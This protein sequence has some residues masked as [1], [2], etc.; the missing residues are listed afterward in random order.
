M[1]VQT[2]AENKIAALNGLR[3]EEVKKLNSLHSQIYSCD[4]CLNLSV[5]C[6]KQH[7]VKSS[8]EFKNHFIYCQLSLIF[9]NLIILE[10]LCV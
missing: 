6:I 1:R 2:S 3:S 4:K 8:T 10:S 7:D 9:N 5:H